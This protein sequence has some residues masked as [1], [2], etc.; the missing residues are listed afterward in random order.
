MYSSVLS[1]SI[2]HVHTVLA[3]ARRGSRIPKSWSYEWEQPCE[4]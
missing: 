2:C 3:E 4:P 1:A